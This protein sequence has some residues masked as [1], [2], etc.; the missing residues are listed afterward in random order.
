M[1]EVKNLIQFIN[2]ARY[3]K[4]GQQAPKNSCFKGTV[5]PQSIF[6]GS[7]SYFEYTERYVGKECD[8]L[9]NYTGRYGATVSS[10]GNLDSKEKIDEFKR[11]GVEALNKEGA[12]CYEFV[13]SMKD[14]ET[15]A[16]YNIVNQEQFSAVIRRIA[17]VYFKSIGLDPENVAWW[18]DFHPENRTS[19]IP[20]PH[21]HFLFFENE[22]TGTF[23]KTYGKLPKKALDDFKR[24]FANQLLKREDKGAY[25]DLF[26]NINISRKNV[27]DNLKHADLNKVKSLKDLYAVLPKSGRLQINSANMAPYRDTVFKV[28][29]DLLASNECRKTWENY[30]SSLERY[31]DQ[32]N[33]KAGSDVSSRKE[34]EISKL[35]DQIA[36]YILSNRKG[37]IEENSYGSILKNK[38]YKISDGGS[39]QLY[40]DSSIVRGRLSR[41]NSAV[42]TKRAINGLIAKRQREI[43]R[44]IDQYLNMDS[45]SM[46]I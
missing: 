28:V 5:T 46:E 24:L 6:G 41:R 40:K 7:G 32:I 30:L 4:I 26:D 42:S 12:I 13:L 2:K 27:L 43:E 17:P 14:Y 22:P 38:N 3:F 25:R 19:T 36:N 8:S 33:R 29:D 18:E 31:E 20:H 44:E 1:K 15:A 45:Y 11:R 35:K 21:I 34:I 23:N 10:L 9:M 39:G 37:Y 16:K